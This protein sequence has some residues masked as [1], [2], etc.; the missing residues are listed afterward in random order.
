VEEINESRKA[1]EKAKNY[2]EGSELSLKGVESVANVQKSFS[3]FICVIVAPHRRRRRI[4]GSSI[5]I[6]PITLNLVLSG[7]CFV[8]AI[9]DFGT[10][11]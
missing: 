10:Q 1:V 11:L 2:L 4:I 5:K 6:I 8:Y 7:C 9:G 3:L